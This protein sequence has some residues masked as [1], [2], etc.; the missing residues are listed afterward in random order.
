MSWYAGQDGEQIWIERDALVFTVVPCAEQ[1]PLEHLSY[2][3]VNT[4]KAVYQEAVCDDDLGGKSK[5]KDKSSGR[6]RGFII[7]AEVEESPLTRVVPWFKAVARKLLDISVV[8]RVDADDAVNA[9]KQAKKKNEKASQ[10]EVPVPTLG[11]NECRVETTSRISHFAHGPGYR[12]EVSEGAIVQ[13]LH[14]FTCRKEI[15]TKDWNA[16]LLSALESTGSHVMLLTKDPRS[17]QVTGGKV[18]GDEDGGDVKIQLRKDK[19]QQEENDWLKSLMGCDDDSEQPDTAELL[20]EAKVEQ[21]HSEV[22][23]P[24]SKPPAS[25]SSPPDEGVVR[26]GYAPSLRVQHPPSDVS[27]W[28]ALKPS[29]REQKLQR[30]SEKGQVKQPPPVPQRP[31][32]RAAPSTAPWAWVNGLH[33]AQGA[34]SPGVA[35]SAPSEPPPAQKEAP[36]SWEDHVEDQPQEWQPNWQSSRA[37]EWASWGA[38]WSTAPWQENGW[39]QGE[40]EDWQHRRRDDWHGDIREGRERRHAQRP[41]GAQARKCGECGRGRP[42]KMFEDD[43][44]WY[45]RV[46]WVEFYGVEPPAKS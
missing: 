15:S 17:G 22:P 33:K 41:S 9:K 28:D 21:P 31:A 29:G 5:K 32:S 45:C 1:L 36:M 40:Q 30:G 20:R 6:Q 23:P 16:L 2:L 42:L 14:M 19:A 46:C 12:V 26:S 43:G 8:S 35:R 38:S 34:L 13:R 7:R 37:D 18:S 4:K 39:Q 27:R 10:S 3:A 11:A 25:R 24:K 44:V